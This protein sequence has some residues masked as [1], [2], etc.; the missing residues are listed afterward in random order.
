MAAARVE[1]TWQA[2]DVSTSLLGDQQSAARPDAD[3]LCVLEAI[4]PDGRHECGRLPRRSLRACC[5]QPVLPQFC[6]VVRQ[7]KERDQAGPVGGGQ[8]E[9]SAQI[10]LD[11]RQRPCACVPK[12]PQRE[13]RW[14]RHRRTGSHTPVAPHTPNR[15]ATKKGSHNAGGHAAE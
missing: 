12:A 15:R 1:Q 13:R 7:H 10:V 9:H 11:L 8:Y 3:A 6:R 5:R 4:K 2:Q 14:W